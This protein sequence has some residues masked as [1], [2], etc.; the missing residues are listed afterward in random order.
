MWPNMVVVHVDRGGSRI[1]KRI[2]VVREFI[3]HPRTTQ[4]EF[5][6]ANDFFVSITDFLWEKIGQ[7]SSKKANGT[8][9]NKEKDHCEAV[10][11]HH[12]SRRLQVRVIVCEEK[13]LLTSSTD[14]LAQPLN[15]R[16]V[17]EAANRHINDSRKKK[18]RWK[19]NNNFHVKL[20]T[21]D[22]I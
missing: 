19:R 12:I 13:N 1:A 22:A 17:A 16:S 8:K 5:Q 15:H 3:S 2:L 11:W 21:F 4:N 9:Q 14:H 6:M 18:R 20:T 7:K 10:S